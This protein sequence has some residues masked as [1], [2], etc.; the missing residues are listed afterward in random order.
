MT[1]PTAAGRPR[2]RSRLWPGR[3]R[4]RWLIDILLIAGGLVSVVFE[5]FSVGIHSIIGLIF[6]G[7]VG[8]HQWHR[9][10]W[11][12]GTLSRLR[13]RR[14]L[15]AKVHW[16]LAQSFLLLAL[17]AVVTASGL[18]DWLDVRTRIRW[19]AISSVILI[20]VAARHGWTRRQWLLRRRRT[21]GSS[22]ENE[23]VE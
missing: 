6:A 3:T 19:H 8:P 21:G 23:A 12:R 17:V 4:R 10:S 15:S 18:Y 2:P 16:S 20:V 1:C 9:R 22:P 11:T 7:T 14:R 5:P 13:Q